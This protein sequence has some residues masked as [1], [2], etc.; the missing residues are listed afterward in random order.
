MS[1]PSSILQTHL[2]NLN[3]DSYPKWNRAYEVLEPVN[4]DEMKKMIDYL[5]SRNTPIPP[6]S[7]TLGNI[8]SFFFGKKPVDNKYDVGVYQEIPF[9]RALQVWREY[10]EGRLAAQRQS[11]ARPKGGKSKKR[12]KRGKFRRVKSNKSRRS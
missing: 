10:E 11:E 1:D 6:K 7:T 12:V 2:D 8:S 4:P 9:K 3:N 5:E